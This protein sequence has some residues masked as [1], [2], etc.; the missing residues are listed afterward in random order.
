VEFF[1]TG[2]TSGNSVPGSNNSFS[3]IAELKVEELAQYRAERL[4]DAGIF[5]DNN[6]FAVLVKR[7]LTNPEDVDGATADP[8]VANK[9]LA[10][11]QYDQNPPAGCSR[12]HSPVIACRV[13]AGDLCF[14]SAFLKP[15]NRIK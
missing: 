8:G 11:G 1:T 15:W 13:A 7:F 3:A 10:T 6:G 12:R 9:F 14:R 2:T 5:L 4:H